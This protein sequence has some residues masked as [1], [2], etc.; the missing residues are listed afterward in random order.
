MHEVLSRILRILPVMPVIDWNLSTAA[1][2]QRGRWQSDFVGFPETQTQALDDLLHIDAQKASLQLNTAQFVAGFPANNALLWGAR[3]AGKSSLIH[4]LLQ[5][6]AK[7]G[8]RLVELRKGDMIEVLDTSDQEWW[9][10]RLGE[11]VSMM[12][13]SSFFLTIIV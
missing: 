8:L 11:L 12:S 6:Y 10:G 3:G 7:D 1:V 13:S 5:E 9:R 4:G 2:W